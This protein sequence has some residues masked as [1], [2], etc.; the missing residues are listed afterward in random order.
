MKAGVLCA[1]VLVAS[2]L[3]CQQYPVRPMPGLRATEAPARASFPNADV[4]AKAYTNGAEIKAIFNAD[5]M[6][7]GVLPVLLLVDNRSS[8]E[9]E[10][11]RDRIE[12]STPSGARM[13]PINPDAAT[14]DQG[15]NAL[16]EAVL[17][18][19]VFSYADAEKYNNEMR[20]DWV[21]KA[22]PEVQIVRS[23]LTTSKFL[24]FNV[25]KDYS[26]AGSNLNV[27][28]QPLGGGPAQTLT[29]KL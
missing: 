5:L 14:T 22:V 6:S 11:V 21:D 18:F 3:G 8:N 16:A 23:G 24:Y 27:V 26:L 1:L 4:G 17:F 15:R 7:K 28:I 13:Q 29:L 12:L 2:A 25:G 19:G 20:R 10:I 9:L